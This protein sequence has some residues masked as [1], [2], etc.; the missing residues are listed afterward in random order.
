MEPGS[1][2]ILE[3]RK[4]N[5]RVLPVGILV[6]DVT[7]FGAIQSGSK[8]GI[9]GNMVV[10][11]CAWL[12][13]FNKS[14]F[15]VRMCCR[16]TLNFPFEAIGTVQ[17]HHST[18]SLCVVGGAR[19]WLHTWRVGKIPAEFYPSY[20]CPVNSCVWR[21]RFRYNLVG[22]RRRYIGKR[23]LRLRCLCRPL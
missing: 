16:M 12:I 13:C 22:L 19:C 20:P 21:L 3:G 2:S 6:Y 15:K 10:F 18:N 11:L 5:R 14:V 9:A 4:S 8:G 23:L 17:T 7:S 1:G